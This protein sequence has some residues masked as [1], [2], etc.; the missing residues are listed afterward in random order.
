M[1][2]TLL[3]RLIT[4]LN[5]SLVLADNFRNEPIKPIQPFIITE[6]DK[7]ELG[8]KLFGPGACLSFISTT[9][10]D[11]FCVQQDEKHAV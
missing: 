11:Y 2:K 8:K 1:Y 10:G 9:A 5:L 7:V 3:V 4:F 6:P